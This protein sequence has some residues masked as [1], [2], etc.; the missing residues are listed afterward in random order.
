[1]I[2]NIINTIL[3]STEV[4][5]ILIISLVLLLVLCFISIKLNNVHKA[6]ILELKG[7]DFLAGC[8]N[9]DGFI[10]QLE[11]IDNV[12]LWNIIC[13]DVDS[14]KQINT[15][16]SFKF[17]DD[18][19]KSIS[20]RLQEMIADKG[21]IAR[22]ESNRFLLGYP[23]ED[24]PT[25]EMIVAITNKISKIDYNFMVLDLEFTFGSYTNDNQ[26]EISQ[27]VE[28]AIED[29]IKAKAH[30]VDLKLQNVESAD[31]YEIVSIAESARSAREEASMKLQ[32]AQN[33]LY[34][35]Q[36]THDEASERMA[37]AAQ[38]L[39]ESN[40]MR[41]EANEK[42]LE[43]KSMTLE[44]ENAK[45]QAKMILDEAQRIKDEANKMKEDYEKS[46]EELQKEKL[47]NSKDK[48]ESQRQYQE[49][50]K[51]K[52]EAL[53]LQDEA[54]EEI[55]KSKEIQQ[56]SISQREEIIK[57]KEEIVKANEEIKKLKSILDEDDLDDEEYESKSRRRKRRE[58]Q[59]SRI[60]IN[61]QQDSMTERRVEEIIN[62]VLKRE[63]KKSKDEAHLDSSD[64]ESMVRKI[65]NESL[66][67]SKNNDVKSIEYHNLSKKDA[68]KL[69]SDELENVIRNVMNEYIFEEY[70][71]KQTKKEKAAEEAEKEKVTE[72]LSRLIDLQ[73][74]TQEKVV[75]NH[76]EKTEDPN[77]DLIHPSVEPDIIFDDDD[78]DEDE[79]LIPQEFIEQLDSKLDINQ[80]KQLFDEYMQM[81]NQ[82]N[83]VKLE[84]PLEKVKTLPFIERV[85]L[86]SRDSKTYYNMIKNAIMARDGI[87]NIVTNRYD[88]FKVGRKVL[89]KI[90]YVGKT[91]K[92]F[93]PLDP[94]LYPNGQCPH[95]DMSSMK[96]HINTPFMI[97]IRSNLGLKRAL[98]LIDDSMIKLNLEKKENY[99]NAD[100]VTRNHNY[101]VKKANN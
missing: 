52:E 37:K 30:R 99:K 70:K 10:K 22:V 75:I 8:Y 17:G 86:S 82:P 93:L 63:E 69:S 45:V 16:H 61:T 90:A 19:I 46:L 39:E 91:L 101:L 15:N 34:E 92:L 59:D 73:E 56:E 6:N 21:I 24:K 54:K 68:E 5:L 47:E 80:F 1:M 50:L 55:N 3:L 13:F 32:L 74:K 62:S 11:K 58:Y 20:S 85:D 43:A 28:N 83:E 36:R 79:S 65:V 4:T 23:K 84:I 38:Q 100:F 76:E 89:F 51:I 49:A 53:K 42:I 48:D 88:T 81:Y 33:A 57:L 25:N 96:K 29:W 72:L 78:E 14:F 26:M 64:I 41:Q 77:I 9:K 71:E 2:F 67:S 12:K 95:K 87:I 27:I 97:K 94:N 31:N 35:A 60:F 66:N 44:G 40:I 18:V 98:V 7:Q